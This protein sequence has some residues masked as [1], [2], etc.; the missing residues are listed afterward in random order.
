MKHLNSSL[1]ILVAGALTVSAS[2]QTAAMTV[3]ASKTSAPISPLMYGF[4]TE[5]LGNWYEGGL[6][7]EMLGD[8]KFFYPV[9]SSPAQTPPNSRRFVGRWR[10]V[11][12]DEFVTMDHD[13]AWVGQHSPRVRLETNAPHGIQ[14]AGL[15]LVQGKRYSGRVIL[16]ADAGAAVTVSLVWGTNAADRET[17]SIKGLRADYAKFP[18]SF[19]A[20]AATMEGRL[21]I[22]GT[23]QG[24]L[25]VGAVSLM[26]ADN[27]NGFRADLI[28]ALKDIGPT[29]L[30]WPGGNSTS[31]YDW[32][33]GIGDSDKRSPRYDFAWKALEPNDV[34]T[35][36]FMALT[37][38]LRIEPYICVNAGFGDAHSAAEW[39]EYFNGAASTPMGKLRAANGHAEPYRV[40]WWNIG[41]EMYGPWQLGHMSLAHYAIKHNM[42]AQAM[43]QVDPTI[44]IVASGATPAE[45]STTGAARTI[46]GNA[47]A[48]FGS[49]VVDWT[50]GLLAN[51]A[52]FFD[53]IAEHLYP[54]AN[55]AFDAEKQQ[56]VPVEDSLVDRARRLPNR[57]RCAVEAWQ[58]YQKRFPALK[59]DSIPIA[60]D[61][62]VP[63]N[64]G[65]RTT[66]F[67]ALS[68]AEA[69]H[70][71]FRNSGLF[72]MSAYTHAAGLL[73]YDKTSANI[74][75]VGL[76]F[77]L[78]RRHFGTI[79]VAVAGNSPQHDVKGTVGVD[80]PKIPS[81]G[82][83]YPLDVTAAL[84]ADGKVLTVAI[85]NATEE[86]QQMDVT[87]RGVTLQPQ[88]R[89]WRIAATDLN[90]RNEPGK[91][92]AVDIAQS[93]LTA[94]PGHLA[95]PKLSIGIYEFPVR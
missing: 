63:G 29:I 62:W 35:D 93:T 45:M 6:W 42:F 21:E 79:P 59:M 56:F 38:I 52:G 30:R 2:A 95:V 17:V 26:P 49:P 34:G 33:D 90:P 24:S 46:T 84:T 50:G 10:P 74:Q 48:E 18:F 8:R 32:R 61:E 55:T 60:L 51:S 69:M 70:E 71:L 27:V 14:Q 58:E 37:R 4:F 91:P 19:T 75:P 82:D 13:R 53:A 73:T 88:G 15:G 16:A 54:K 36:E 66:M 47:V 20:G 78:Y 77:E 65:T 80:K 7:A 68:S 9:D 31:G 3:D 12:P 64:P 72:M 41:N 76:M 81:G 11:G 86:E 43:R 22:A 67:T 5:L 40:K 85:V 57:V 25:H 44:K 94:V 87:F 1:A 83:T 28:A 23:G 89:L 92:R 39:V